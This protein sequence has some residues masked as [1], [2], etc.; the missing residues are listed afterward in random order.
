MGSRDSPCRCRCARATST[1]TCS[2][3]GFGWTLV[4]TG[5]SLPES[6]RFR[7]RVARQPSRVSITHFHPDHVGGAGADRPAGARVY[8]RAR[9]R[10]V[11][12]RLGKRHLAAGD[13]RLVPRNARPPGVAN[14]LLEV[15]LPRAVH[16]LCPRSRAAP[17]GDRVD[18][19][20][21]VATPG[22]ADVTSFVRDGVLVAGDHL[23]RRSR[24]RSGSTGLAPGPAR[25]RLP[26]VARAD[27]AAGLHL[28][29]PGHGE[30]MEDP[31]ASARSSSPSRA[32]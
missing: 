12:P 19:W 8:Q 20:E 26:R 16:P 11:R 22:H 27:R 28:A 5:L 21:V 2:R 17:P 7:E 29:L 31:S 10:A 9:L 18:G 13:R 23:P 3:R 1:P 15:G 4:D 24:R 25:A 32:A 6:E 30:P 14:E